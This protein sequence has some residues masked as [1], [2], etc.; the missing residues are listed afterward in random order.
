[1]IIL[2]GIASKMLKK[3]ITYVNNIKSNSLLIQTNNTFRLDKA[4]TWYLGVNY[5]F[6]DKQQIEL[7]QLKALS[8]LDVNIKKLWN[9]WT[10]A[11]EV[12][13]LLRTN[14]VVITDHSLTETLTM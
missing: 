3:P 4:K 8:S 13:D 14:K 11:L 5:F 7:G 9:D 12:R 6:V 2:P 1:M 10:F